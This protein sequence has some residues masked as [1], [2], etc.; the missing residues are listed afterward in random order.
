VKTFHC[1]EDIENLAAQGKTE[2]IIDENTMLTDLARDTARQL[3]ISLL[4]RSRSKP[5]AVVP[6]VPPSAPPFG[7]TVKLGARPKGCQHGPLE[8]SGPK[9]ATVSKGSSA[10]VD[11]LVE[12]VKRLGDDRSGG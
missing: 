11:Q 5:M 9:Q 2:L 12:L 8:D 6:S 10:V 7:S 1:A 4:Y 3:G